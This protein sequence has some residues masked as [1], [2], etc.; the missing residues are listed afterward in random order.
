MK[1]TRYTG[2][3]FFSNILGTERGAHNAGLDII[4]ST[5]IDDTAEEAH[6]YLKTSP[7]ELFIRED[8][9]NLH[10]GDIRRDKLK[11][12]QRIL[13]KNGI[14]MRRG[15]LDVLMGGPPCFGIT[16]LSNNRSLFS[17]FNFLMLQM[18]RLIKEM[19]PKVV[20]M[21][22]VP[23]LLSQQMK[24]FFYLLVDAINKLG[25]YEWSCK[26]LNAKNFGCNQSR[27]RVI[28]ILVRKDLGVKPSFPE[29]QA[30]DLNKQSAYNVIGAELIKYKERPNH[31]GKRVQRIINGKTNLFPTLTSGRVEIFR[32][33]IWQDLTVEDRK[34]VAHMQHFPQNTPFSDSWIAER[35]GL[36][37]L[38]P[39]AEALC[40]HIITEILDKSAYA[41]QPNNKAA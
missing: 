12:I 19:Q 29:P 3:G 35:L 6:P 32:N 18:L 10:W 30:V 2:G 37:V 24:P 26:T 14:Y 22:Q 8:I 23:M 28:F 21:E 40:R 39:F 34:A 13:S 31:E 4:L 41:I 5:D 36:I 25:N 11:D 17:H 33:G 15:E 9:Y 16:L 1:R 38:P 27:E 20:L 7:S